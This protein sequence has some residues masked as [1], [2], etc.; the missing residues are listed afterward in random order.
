MGSCIL[1]IHVYVCSRVATT[2]RINFSN[3][4]RYKIQIYMKDFQC[5]SLRFFSINFKRFIANVLINDRIRFFIRSHVSRAA[6]SAMFCTRLK[7]NVKKFNLKTQ[8]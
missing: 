4:I 5:V 2:K 7:K 6:R 3:Q 1:L 8:I